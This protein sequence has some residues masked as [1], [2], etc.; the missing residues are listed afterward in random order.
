MKG[1]PGLLRRQWIARPLAA[2]AVCF[3]L[4]LLW[5]DGCPLPALLLLTLAAVL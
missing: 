3:L 5:G 4:G 1:L 2:F